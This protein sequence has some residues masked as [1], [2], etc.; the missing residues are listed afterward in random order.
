[1][2]LFP[3]NNKLSLSRLLTQTRLWL[4][5]YLGGSKAELKEVRATKAAK[6]AGFGD[7][8]FPLDVSG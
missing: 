1:M 3:S 2:E 4:A 5:E 7:G 6:N 8:V